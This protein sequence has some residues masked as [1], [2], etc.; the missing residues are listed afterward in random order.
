M[1]SRKQASGKIQSAVVSHSNPTRSSSNAS[2]TLGDREL[3]ENAPNASSS[4][5]R[6]LE[7][8][9]AKHL[10]KGDDLVSTVE[11]VVEPDFP[12]GGWRAWSVVFGVS[13][14]SSSCAIF[15]QCLSHLGR[16]RH[17]IHFWLCQFLGSA[18]RPRSF[19]TISNNFVLGI[20]IILRKRQVSK[21]VAVLNVSLCDSLNELF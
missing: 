1:E 9:K 17:N 4:P 6:S 13:K 12:D 15:T 11:D 10:E 21:S 5:K 20:S 8:T 14:V 2:V 19:C 3:N 18:S 7:S 16:L